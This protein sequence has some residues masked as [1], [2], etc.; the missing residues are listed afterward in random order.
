MC[1]L[2][3][4]FLLLECEEGAPTLSSYSELQLE[5][6][7]ANCGV[8]SIASEYEKIIDSM[9]AKYDALY[10]QCCNMA[11]DI[12]RKCNCRL[13]KC[14]NPT[15]VWTRWSLSAGYRGG[16]VPQIKQL[17]VVDEFFIGFLGKILQFLTVSTY[18]ILLYLT[19]YPHTLVQ[20]SRQLL[21]FCTWK[22]EV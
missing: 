18:K 11:N 1:P 20:K 8:E 10:Y 9:Q 12:Q 5:P 21:G 19:V 4:V 2:H 14:P 15:T 17:Q 7:V 16:L 13:G 22:G 3:L 6:A